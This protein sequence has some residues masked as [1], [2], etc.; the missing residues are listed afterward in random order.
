M[1]QPIYNCRKSHWFE[2][3]Q[4]DIIKDIKIR[5]QT[6]KK[7]LRREHSAIRILNRLPE[8]LLQLCL[9]FVPEKIKREYYL[10][11]ITNLFKKYIDSIENLY[12]SRYEH[13][14]I[15]KLIMNIPKKYL[16]QFIKSG[17]PSRY[18]QKVINHTLFNNYRVKK[19]FY[20]TLLERYKG[21]NNLTNDICA[22]E[23]TKLVK[24]SFM[25]V[26]G[27]G[28]YLFET[29]FKKYKE[30]ELHFKKYEKYTIRLLN[31]IIYLHD[32]Y[33]L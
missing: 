4:E 26:I 6:E 17:T 2:N 8:E 9:E 3:Y 31:S 15:Y 10:T 16:I 27:E 11:K 23:I 33:C 7:E 5:K 24:F 12:S 14:P 13:Y 20:K 21:H 28:N 32:K 25:E 22:W 30:Y 18:Y 29:H 19:S 1:N